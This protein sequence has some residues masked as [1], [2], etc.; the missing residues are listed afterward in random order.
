MIH[1]QYVN[2]R[3]LFADIIDISAPIIPSLGMMGNLKLDTHINDIRDW[4]LSAYDS[5]FS[6]RKLLQ[7]QLLLGL[8]VDYTY[9]NGILTFSVDIC[10]GY[11]NA[12]TCRRGYLGK[13]NDDIYIGN[14]W[15]NIPNRLE[16]FDAY[17]GYSLKS[18][19][20]ELQ[21]LSIL[22]PEHLAD[23]YDD[24][25]ELP[26]FIIEEIGIFSRYIDGIDLYKLYYTKPP[27]E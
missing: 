8:Q 23:G 13:F 15:Y 2:P 14:S 17:N 16:V 6:S 19:L 3:Y 9:R 1:R 25:G 7:A 11:I 26:D 5:T 12:I 4:L 27:I 21:G 10:T 22:V 24:L 18:S 20:P